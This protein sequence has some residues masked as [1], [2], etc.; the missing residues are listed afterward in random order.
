MTQVFSILLKSFWILKNSYLIFIL[1]ECQTLQRY[2]ILSTRVKCM[3]NSWNC[4][5]ND[6]DH[7]NKREPFWIFYPVGVLH[8]SFS[9][10]S[11]HVCKIKI[12]LHQFRLIWFPSKVHRSVLTQFLFKHSKKRDWTINKRRFINVLKHSSNKI[13]WN[14]KLSKII[15]FDGICKDKVIVW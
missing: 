10:F 7:K 3:K 2:I 1:I 6:E 4:V 9:F 15:C 5:K 13:M 14:W 11:V 12:Y 8:L